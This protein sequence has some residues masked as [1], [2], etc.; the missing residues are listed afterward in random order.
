[1]SENDENC[2]QSGEVEINEIIE[3]AGEA[4]SV[5]KNEGD[6]EDFATMLAAHE[7]QSQKIQPGQKVGGTIITIDGDY[8]FID[9]GLKEDGIMEL[10]DLQDTNGE[11]NAKAGD[12]VEAF[13]VSISPQ[14]IRRRV[15]KNSMLLPILASLS[16]VGEGSIWLPGQNA[17]CPITSTM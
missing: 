4:V 10:K 2:R 15:I 7:L 1:M 9:I 3:P 8:A 11:I 12:I 13:V 14:G 16:P 5:R 6:S 17:R